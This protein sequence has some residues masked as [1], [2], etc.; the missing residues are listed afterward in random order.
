MKRSTEG[1][2]KRLRVPP[3]WTGPVHWVQGWSGLRCSVLYLILHAKQA[4][5]LGQ[6]MVC[7]GQRIDQ[8]VLR[9]AQKTGT[10]C[11]LHV[12]TW[13]WGTG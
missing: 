3:L 2:G 10:G 11:V 5:E 4:P 1:P 8:P 7:M 6:H 13:V 9:V 12:T